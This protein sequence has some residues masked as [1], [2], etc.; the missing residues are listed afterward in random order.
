M[1]IIWSEKYSVGFEE[2]DNQHRIL[3]E[4]INKLEEIYQ[5]RLNYT[6]FE[7]VLEKCINE[8]KTYTILHF[9]TEEILMKMFTYK[10]FDEHKES[11]DNF[12]NVVIEEKISIFQLIKQKE[13]KDQKTID[14]LN[15][16]IYEKIESIINF[17]Q[18]W[19][20]NHILKS[21]VDFVEFFFKLRNKADKVG[22]WDKF[23]E[24]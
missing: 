18:Q 12:I 5:N 10:D 19:F 20:I 4:I 7:G 11:H 21:D 6:N 17:L 13:G 24:D 8:L 3:V 23:L 16:E 2:I 1:P 14:Q 15:Q 9:S 22:G